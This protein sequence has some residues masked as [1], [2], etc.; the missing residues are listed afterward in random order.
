MNRRD[1]LRGAM[2]TVAYGVT[3]PRLG[4][5]AS[6]ADNAAPSLALPTAAQKA[7]ADMELGMFFHFDIPIYKTGWRWRSF[8]NYPDPS[9][10][11]PARLDTD[12]W[13]EA[14]KAYGAKYVVFVAKHCSGFLQWQSDLYPYGVKQSAWRS[15]KGDL[16]KDFVDSARR[17]GLKPGLYASVSANSFLGVDTPGR[18]KAK[19]WLGEPS[20]EA[21]K[22]YAKVC[23]GMAEELWTRYG[24]L[25][26]IWFD[27]GALPPSEGGLDLLPILQRRQPDAILFQGPRNADNLI[28]WVGNERGIAPYPC[29]STGNDVTQSDGVKESKSQRNTGTPDGRKWMP[30]ECDVPLKKNGWFCT[31]NGAYW[32]MDYLI[33]MYDRSVGRN[34]NLLLNAAPQPDG[35]IADNEM[36]IYEEFG[37]RIKARHSNRLAAT[38]GEGERIELSLPKDGG[39]VNQ[40]VIMERIE[41]GERVRDFTLEAQSGDGGWREIYKG[42]CIGHKHIVRFDKVETSRLRLSVA[43]SAATPLIRDFSAY[44]N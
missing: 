17:F 41:R 2:A 34:C 20:P 37:R 15:G 18:V 3:D 44:C 21:Q 42:S 28:R 24:E 9:L 10:Y 35:L 5:A 30:G 11:N 22:R 33:D 4:F 27:G 16:V 19:G 39:P 26:E 36:K 8:A 1:F 43:K 6:L 38:E 12:Q 25:G 14:A 7:W 32:T 23:E 13:M 31:D 29:W 40:V